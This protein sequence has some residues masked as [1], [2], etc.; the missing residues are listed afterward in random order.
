VDAA[1]VGRERH[2]DRRV[3]G[4]RRHH[5][6]LLLQQFGVPHTRNLCIPS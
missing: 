3:A 1:D 6:R 4:R 5:L 2:P